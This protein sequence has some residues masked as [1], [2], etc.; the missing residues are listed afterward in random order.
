MSYLEKEAAAQRFA[1]GLLLSSHGR[2]GDGS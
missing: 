1:A 2:M